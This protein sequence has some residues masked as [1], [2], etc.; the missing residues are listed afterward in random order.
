MCSTQDTASQPA[1]S[2][3][4][5]ASQYP[6]RYCGPASIQPD[7]ASQPASDISKTGGGPPPAERPA[8]I[9]AVAEMHGKNDSFVGVGQP[10]DSDTDYIRVDEATSR[11]P[12]VGQS[13]DEDGLTEAS[14]A[15]A[16]R[17]RLDESG[18]KEAETAHQRRAGHNVSMTNQ[19]RMSTLDHFNIEYSS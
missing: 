18:S 1:S 5:R 12:T 3:I 15:P 8:Y 2:Q 7:T 19:H 4:L 16:K 9:K 14:A 10:S 17:K 6:A 13:A 11:D